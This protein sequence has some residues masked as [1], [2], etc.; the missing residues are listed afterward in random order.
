MNEEVV[1]N[2]DELMQDDDNGQNEKTSLI[3]SKTKKD[4]SSLRLKVQMKKNYK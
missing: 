3:L 1:V 2:P 4:I